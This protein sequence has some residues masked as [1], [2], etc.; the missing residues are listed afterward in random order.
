MER[1]MARIN[2]I[3][4]H[5]TDS[6]LIEEDDSMFIIPKTKGDIT[7]LRPHFYDHDFIMVFNE[8]FKSKSFAYIERVQLE[9]DSHFRLFPQCIIDKTDNLFR[10]VITIPL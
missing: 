7:K 3:S 2:H 4:F 6:I 1:K 8:E 10:I 5:G 9:P